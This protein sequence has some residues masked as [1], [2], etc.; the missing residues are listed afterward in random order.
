MNDN[1]L[2]DYMTVFTRL[3]YIVCIY[4]NLVIYTRCTS[5]FANLLSCLVLSFQ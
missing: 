4:D 1:S 2:G 5:V 3:D